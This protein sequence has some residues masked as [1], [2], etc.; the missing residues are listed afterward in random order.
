MKKIIAIC[1]IALVSFSAAAVC[2]VCTVAVGAGLEGARLLGVDDVITGVWAGGFTLILFFW[3]AKFLKKRNVQNALWYVGAFAMW[4]VLLGLLYLTP[5]LNYGANTLWGIDKFML[6]A[7]AGAVA[8][9]AAER[10]W[11]TSSKSCGFGLGRACRRACRA[12]VPG[13]RAP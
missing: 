9:Y 7:T 12:G 1:L 13:G 5:N 11:F 10:C 8:L 4:V 6:G 2:P 3:T